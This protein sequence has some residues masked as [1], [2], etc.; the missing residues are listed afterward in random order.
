[1]KLRELKA[2]M[3]FFRMARDL[4]PYIILKFCASRRNN[5]SCSPLHDV[6][7]PN[8]LQFEMKT[9]KSVFMITPTCN[10]LSIV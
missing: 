9:I 6:S 2:L 4:N 1:L 8:E 10:K 3:Q 5:L 7:I